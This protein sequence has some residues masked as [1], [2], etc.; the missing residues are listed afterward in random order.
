MPDEHEDT[1]TYKLF[2]QCE[3]MVNAL[4]KFGNDHYEYNDY[5]HADIGLWMSGLEDDL[6]QICKHSVM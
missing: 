5:N 1:P 2:I 4:V 6:M 3:M